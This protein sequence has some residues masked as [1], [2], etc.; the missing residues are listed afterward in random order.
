VGD[1]LVIKD[2]PDT[3]GSFV[4]PTPTKLGMYPKYQPKI[5]SDTTYAQRPV[6][7]IQGHD[8]S[9]MVAFNDYRDAI[10]LEFELRVYNNLKT[11]Y[12]ADLFDVNSVDVGAFRSNQFDQAEINRILAGDFIKWAGFYGIDYTTNSVFDDTNP[13]TWN[14]LGGYSNDLQVPVSG[15]WRSVFKYFYDT[16]RP[17]TNPWEM[18]GFTEQPEWWHDTY[19]PAPYTSGNKI[20]WKDLEN[21]MVRGPVQQVNSFYARPGLSKVLPVDEM[22]NL[23]DLS[24]SLISNITAYNRRQSWVFGDQSPAETAWRRSSYWPFAVQRLLAL[25][26]P[27]SYSALMYDPAHM[28]KNIAGQWSYGSDYTFLNPANLSVHGE[29]SVATSGYG[30]YVSEIGKQR[31]ANYIEQLRQDLTYLNFN[32]F[33][34]VGGFVSQDKLQVTIDAYDPTSTSVGALLSQDDYKLRL[35]VSNPIKSVGI[36]GLIVQRSNGVF[37]VKGYDKS[38]PYFNVFSSIRNSNTSALTVGGVSESYVNWGASNTGGNTGLSSIDLTTAKSAAVG[39]FYQQGQIVAYAGKFYRVTVSHKS[40]NTFNTAYFQIMPSLPTRGG[41]TVQRAN[42]F[43]TDVTMIPYGTEFSN[44]QD[45][46]DLIIGY[47]RWLVSQGFIFDEFN[48]DFGSLVDWDFTAKEFLYWSTQNW[49]NNSVITL[50]P[51]ANQL[52]YQLTDAVVDNVFDSFYEY[53]LQRA[54][55]TSFPQ[56]NLKISR[57]DGICSITSTNTG[58]GIYFARLN[59]VQKEHV[60]VFNNTTMFN[61]T[62]YDIETGYRQARVR[63]S[64]FRTAGWNGD[65]FSPGFVYDT[66]Q[67]TNWAQHQDYKIGSLVRFNGNYYAANSNIAGAASFDFSMWDLLGEKPVAG[68]IPNFDYKIKQFEDFYSLDIDNFDAGQEKMAQHLTGYTPR[69]YLNNIFT[70]PISQYKFYQGF[71]REKGTKNSISKLAKASLHNMQGELTYTEEWAFRV[72]QYGSYNTYQELE[73]PMVEGNFLENPQIIGFVD[74][75]VNTSSVVTYYITPQDITITPSKYNSSSTFA[76]NSGTYLEN[77]FVLATAGYARLD[78]VTATAY[79]ENSLLDIANNRNI[80]DGDVVWLGF[81]QNGDWDVLRYEIQKASITGVFVSAP[82]STITFSTDLFHGLSVGDIVSVTEF[83][84]QV[85][86]VYFVSAIPHLN[87]FTVASTLLSITNAELLSAGKLFKFASARISNFDSL[88]SDKIL[89][90]FPAQSLT[91]VDDDGNGRWV[92][93]QKVNNYDY[94]TD[95]V[96]FANQTQQ[97]GWKFGRSKQ[98]DFFVVSAPYAVQGTGSG[99]RRGLVYGYKQTS[100]GSH[101]MFSYSLNHSFDSYTAD[102]TKDTQFGYSLEYDDTEFNNSGYGLIFAG[103]PAASNVKS[104]GIVAVSTATASPYINQGVVKI[105]SADPLLVQEISQLVLVSPAPGNDQYFGS[106]LYVQKNT[107]TKVVLVGAG[108]TQIVGTGRVFSYSVTTTSTVSAVYNTEILPTGISL[109]SG[110]QWGYSISGSDDASVIAISA[111]GYSSNS[112]IVQVFSGI[113]NTYIQSVVPPAGMVQTGIRF[114]QAV[115]VSPNGQYLFVSATEARD[116]D[117]SY[118]KVVI[119][120]KHSNGKF[121]YDQLLSNPVPEVGMKFGTS[122]DINSANDQLVISAQGTNKT[123]PT[124]F[125]VLKSRTGNPETFDGKSTKFHGTF[126]FEGTVYSYARKSARF[127]L[128]Q[129][130]HPRE[131]YQGSNYGSSVSIDDSGV[132]LVGAPA[133]SNPLI[134]SSFSKFYK[135]DPTVNG[136]NALRTQDSTVDVSVIERVALIDTFNETVMDYLD[137]VDPLKGKIAGLAEQEIKYKSSFDPAVYSIGITGTVNDINSNWLDEHVGE[138]WWDLSTAKYCWYEQGESSYRKSNWGK[139]FPGATI[140]VYEWVGSEHLPTEWSALADTPAGLVDGISGQPKFADNSVVSVKQVFDIAT[141]SF[142]NYYYFWVKNKIT[143][144]EAKNRRLAAYQVASI[145]ADPTAYGLEYISILSRNSLAVS[146]IGTKL[147]GDRISL[148]ISVDTINNT[149]PRHTEWMILS[150]GA[151]NSRPNTLL[152]KKLIDS[153]LGHDSLGNLVPDPTLT[154]RTRYGLGIRPQQT[155]FKDRYQALRNI[156]EFANS[157]LISKQI[158]GNYEFANLNQQEQLPNQYSH[159]YDQIVEDLDSLNNIDVRL[160]SVPELT[161]VVKDG[162]IISVSIVN[163]G[164]GYKISP[165]VGVSGNAIISTEIDGDGK[166]ISATIVDSGIGYSSANPPLLTVRPY[167]VIVLADAQFNNKWSIYSYDTYAKQ[168]VRSHTQKFNTT[169]YWNYV[170]WASS[171]FNK[172]LDYTATVNDVYQL[173]SITL[174]PGQ[175][176]KVNN[177][178]DGRFIILNALPSGSVGTFSPQYDL[179][180]KQQGTIQISNNLWDFA[181]SNYGFDQVSSYDQ[182]LY[183]QTPDIELKYIITALR[184]DLFV[185]DLKVNWNLLFFTAVRYALSEQKLLDWAFKTSFISAVNLAGP[186]DQRPV[187]KLT[188]STYYEQYLDEIKPYHTQVRSYTTNHTLLEPTGTFNTDFDLPAVYDRGQKIFSVLSDTDPRMME[189]PWKS[190]NDQHTYQV[191][192]ISVGDGGSGYMI[193]PAVEIIA[194]DGDSGTGATAQAYI[195]SGKVINVVI[196]NPGK[197]Y[198][199]SPIVKLNGGGNTKLIPA[200]VYANLDNGLVRTNKI[201]MKFDRISRMANPNYQNRTTDNFVCDGSTAAFVLNWVAQPD[202]A[203]ITVLLDGALVFGLDYTIRYYTESHLGYSKQ[204]NEIVLLNKVPGRGQLL[205]V[206]YE[207]NI[208]LLDATQRIVNYYT[209]TSGMPGLDLGQ[210]MT[211]IEYPQTEIYGLPLDYTTSWDIGY[212]PFGT[213]VWADDVNY[214]NLRSAVSTSTE[215]TNVLSLNTTTGLAIGQIV[216]IV[217]T[218]TN[219][220]N[221]TT[222]VTITNIHSGTITVNSTLIQPVYPGEK[223]EFW[224]YDSNSSALDTVIDGGTWNTL[225]NSLIGALGS[226]A[227]DIIIDGDYF[228]TPNTSYAPEELVPGQVLESLGINV[229]TKNPQ[230]APVVVSDSVDIVANTTATR[231][232]SITPPSVDS[233]S[234]TFNGNIFEYTTATTFGSASEFRINWATNEIIVPPQTVDGKLGYTVISIGGGIPEQGAG[235]IDT[236]KI[237]VQNIDTAQLQSLAA[238]VSVNSAYVTVNGQPISDTPST[239]ATWFSLIGVDVVNQRSSVNVYNLNT[240]TNTIIAWFFSTPYKYFNQTRAQTF[241][242]GNTALQSFVL[243]QPPSKIEP[244][245]AQVIVELTD[246][247]GCR[248]LR[249]P[250]ISYYEVKNNINHYA[251]ND[252]ETVPPQTFNLSNVRVY[253]NGILLSSGSSYSV[254]SDTSVV[255]IDGMFINN[256]DVI[257]V[258]AANQGN[259]DYDLTGDTLTLAQPI[260]NSELKVITFADQDGMLMRTE[261]FI[262]N[263][264]RRYV[265]SRPALNNNYVWVELNGIPLVDKV[266]YDILGDDVTVQLSDK[267]VNSTS[268]TVVIISV[269]SSVLATT[270]LGYRIFEDLLGRTHFKRISGKNTTYLTKPLNFNDTEIHVADAG[271]LSPPM[272]S[273]KIPGIVIIAGE[274][275]EFFKVENNVLSKL[276]RGTLGTAPQFYSDVNTKVID[277]SSAQTIPFT[278]KT[279]TQHQLTTSTTN[280]YVISTVTNAVHGDGIVL[281][282]DHEI[283]PIDQVKI[284]YGGRLLSKTA[285]YYQDIALSYDSPM[286]A[287]EITPIDN[288]K[289][290]PRTTIMGKAFVISATNQVWVYTGSK[291]PEA[292]NGYVYHGLDFI[293]PEFTINLDTQTITLNIMGGVRSNL[294]LTIVKKEFNRDTS[295]NDE[296][297]SNQTKSL[298]ESTTIPAKFLQARPTDLPDWYYYGGDLT[299]TSSNGFALTDNNGQP[300]QGY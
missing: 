248:R 63:L 57:Q 256:G 283:Q 128:A 200:T 60:M 54:D 15:Y 81:K 234:V 49:A 211:G 92:V 231:L 179:V 154:S 257:A 197:N 38:N 120:K 144:P 48:Q 184:D 64:G 161:C 265:I 109:T 278:E 190:W 201:S 107:S 113:T 20:L 183:D 50:S 142:Y 245:V 106:S 94:T 61:D 7:V 188:S 276:R 52:K 8:G 194:A 290:L 224:S 2:Y 83:N 53:S 115:L 32:L 116:I 212:A 255:T 258:V 150:E 136:Y 241:T 87:Q 205:V 139:L 93:Y 221:T 157:V 242:I 180:F 137:V 25:T 286:I 187:F 298:M 5:Y 31:T 185:G 267:F 169:L 98:S 131:S 178:G 160:L 291:E 16:D 41:V 164:F 97:L 59:S 156:I 281:S 10:I 102:L 135:L 82:A 101:V 78:D 294:R 195:R 45:V 108:G 191:G 118:G 237:T 249:P 56:N 166:I 259:W 74:S 88:P 55:G 46:Y 300:L 18:L 9:I 232:L 14:Y 138:L 299:L 280:T 289:M 122:L 173:D 271:V 264:S 1:Q 165:T 288:V 233:I 140:D 68:L 143:L 252:H 42:S 279:L 175:Y 153:L 219:K 159:A 110:S 147:V 111:P 287:G 225:T 26:K 295:W 246:I 149:I 129:E 155:L 284:Y 100:T 254:N 29:N 66:A 151:E 293:P 273:K 44:V 207:K 181:D 73:F 39:N 35:N 91:W 95:S 170:D 199:I 84:S 192:S 80:S 21:G 72:G 214:Y 247:H 105:S 19:G 285:R 6:N 11:E 260:T 85:D 250:Y 51:F 103:A 238:R 90:T 196:T 65:Y 23:V 141:Q 17:H 223:I 132:V 296:I 133:Y 13:F 86:G 145:I 203:K 124:T 117:Q 71:I 33:Y 198:K 127:V 282:S 168:W 79:N 24:V 292:M 227:S 123:K 262:G 171:D 77:N 130:L 99:I 228:L 186:L 275:I 89:L 243:S 230:G 297:T 220:F 239:T 163:P 43:S 134:S 266:D 229:Y 268:D 28:T 158:T 104:S 210:L 251:I 176:V 269:S 70:N 204:Y 202:K 218:I 69:V 12:R 119:Y 4:P 216:N 215:G 37:V 209:A 235:V 167:T 277:Q 22:G 222:D 146:N 244:A 240:G 75:S 208:G 3:T 76:V 58:D 162:K 34:K 40:E 274:R 36:S 47:G 263:P 253:V 27:A 148:N 67:I 226:N 152:E 261:R 193:A 112:G 177:G 126:E 121:E 213:T 30:V 96:Q 114:G 206:S 172:Y 236:A 270:I 125:D 174:L 182:T 189:Y 217:S 62:I 272:L